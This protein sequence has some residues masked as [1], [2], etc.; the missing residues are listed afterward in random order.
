MNFNPVTTERY[1]TQTVFLSP[2]DTVIEDNHNR[3]VVDWIDVRYREPH[4]GDDNLVS[5]Y[6][7]RINSKG[8]VAGGV[9]EI[10]SYFEGRAELVKKA[11][12]HLGL[13]PKGNT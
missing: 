8:E 3:Y 10:G 13:Y 1:T 2:D 12:E 6:G 7:H 11:L 4:T 9:L 5:I